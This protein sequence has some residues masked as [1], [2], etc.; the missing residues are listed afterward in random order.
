MPSFILDI[1]IVVVFLIVAFVGYKTGFMATVIKIASA[2]G[3]V[4]IAILCTKPVTTFAIEDLNLAGG[5]TTKIYENITT[6]E[7]FASITVDNGENAVNVVLTKMGIPSFISE[8]IAKYFTGEVDIYEA[9]MFASEK[10]SQAILTVCVF[11][12]LLVFSALL[13]WVL[14]LV[15]KGLRKAVVAI[16]V[17]DGVLGI[18]LYGIIYLAVIY[19]FLLVASFIIQS[20]TNGFTEFML[21][22][23]HLADDNFGI[24]KY[25]YQNNI[26]GNFVLLFF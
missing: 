6:S 17:V 15:I 7:Q 23:L 1:I 16:R 11:L 26:I 13:F 12:F 14:K 20:S 4:V 8:V 18:A 10:I 2:L 5:L 3:G 9:A 24:A 21:G 19:I 25:L 22:Q